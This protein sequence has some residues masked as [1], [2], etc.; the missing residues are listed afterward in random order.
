[1]PLPRRLDRSR[2]L[3]ET[4]VIG[5]LLFFTLRGSDGHV[6]LFRT[7]GT[8][9]GTVRLTPSRIDVLDGIGMSPFAGRL[10]FAARE[11]GAQ[12]SQ[13]WSSDGTRAWTSR[14]SQFNM[15]RRRDGA[16]EPRGGN[17]YLVLNDL[18]N[19]LFRIYPNA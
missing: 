13:F 4:A 16:I 7:D 1:L 8:A 6:S 19:D 11:P 5:K 3:L 18:G 9:T 14:S 10:L 12:T 2:D 15:P 17:L